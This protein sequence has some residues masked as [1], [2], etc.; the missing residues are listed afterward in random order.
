MR[1]DLLDYELPSELIAQHPAADR[2][3][4]RLL[5]VG[6]GDAHEHRTIDDLAE[7]IPDRALLV[8]NDTRVLP[9]RLFAH[10]E[11]G[12]RVEIFLVRRVETR[13]EGGRP[14]EIWRAL[15]KASKSLRF[16]IELRVGGPAKA[17]DAEPPTLFARILTRSEDDGLLEVALY[18]DGR[19][20][21][22][23]AVSA[24][25]RMPLP[26]YIK[27]DV[28][29]AD[30]ERYQTVYAR[31]PGAVAA[32]TAGLHLSR[33]M[34]GRLVA[35]RG[36]EIAAVTLHVGLGTFSPVTAEDLDQHKMHAEW[37]DVSQTT[38]RAVLEAKR[39][40]RPVVAI[41]TTTVRAL[42]SASA[43]GE[44]RASVGETRL[45][46]QPGYQFRSVDMLFTNFH[47][48]KSTLLALVAAFGGTKRVLGAYQQAVAARYRF[49]SYG[50]AM[51]LSRGDEP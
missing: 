32:P 2:Q 5:A 31:V 19:G 28:E 37:F 43:S 49:F 12:G 40:G 10:K 30:A 38:A 22:E 8:L 45:L 21:I 9:A 11:T 35:A 29:P 24:C 17:G 15:G 4:A 41:G 13:V 20:S 23:D 16:G 34:L 48:P 18:T 51:L 42:E 25:G 6:A 1:V 33:A 36:C 7:L 14:V 46:I 26:P 27:R 3:D 50:D 47:L 44:I 39:E